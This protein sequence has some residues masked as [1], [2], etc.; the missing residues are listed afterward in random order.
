MTILLVFYFII[1]MLSKGDVLNLKKYVDWKSISMIISLLLVSRGMELSGAFARVSE[2]LLSLSKNSCK[3]LLI[4]IIFTSA[5]SA[6]VLMND[7]SLFVYVPIILI[8][9]KISSISVPIFITIVSIS[10]NIGSAL[11]P[12]GNPQ[13]IIIWQHYSV[14]FISFIKAIIPFFIISIL[15]LLA[16]SLF[17][18]RKEKGSLIIAKPP[19]IILNKELFISSLLLLI[20][21]IILEEKGFHYFPLFL[22][23][24]VFALIRRE[25]VLGADYALIMIFILMFAD[26]RGLSRVMALHNMIPH[27]SSKISILYWGVLLSQVM[28]NVPATIFLIDNVTNWKVLAIAVNL[29][30]VGLIIGSLANI[31]AIRLGKIKIKEFHKYSL[32]YFLMLLII[33][34]L[35]FLH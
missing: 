20:A 13:N 15:L 4:L 27:I 5:I 12:I 11:T 25:V 1:V 18:I 24:V 30:G 26:F 22:T 17:L 29:G 31:I 9:S 16:Y 28:S 8:V 32:P 7:A 19:K 10:A 6:M 35:I 33:F 3:R 21:D 34:T 23:I 2:R 14:G